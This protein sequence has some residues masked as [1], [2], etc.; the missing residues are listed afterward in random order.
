[1]MMQDDT[2]GNQVIKTRIAPT[3]SG[4]L[5]LGNV[6]SFA[7]TAALAEEMKAKILLRI[8]DLDSKRVTREYVQDIFDTLDFLGI[9]WDEGPANYQ[10]FKAGYSQL[11]RMDLYREAL[12]Q[13]LEHGRIFACICSR[14][15]ISRQSTDGSYPGSCR[16]KNIAAD[17]P[18]TSWRLRTLSPET[19]EVKTARNGVVNAGLPPF[20]HEFI[21]RRRDG[22]PSYQLASLIDDLHY[23]IR[24]VVR[25]E[26]LWDSTLAQLYLAS[27]LEAAFSIPRRVSSTE[28]GAHRTG[29]QLFGSAPEIFKQTVFHHHRLLTG[30]NGRKLSKSAGD[31]SVRYLRRQG[32]K[33][34]EVYALIGSMLGCREPVK[35]RRALAAAALAR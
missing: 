22:L 3:P 6:L 31:I 35:N 30:H 23:G 21:V 16:D 26:D 5:H 18:D 29:P 28:P 19:L 9:P 24:L 4:F 25:G 34:S 1:M 20:M 14:A 10:E 7:I 17:T 33:P 32:K 13:L 8:D 12:R 27:A 15:E 11:H 2:S